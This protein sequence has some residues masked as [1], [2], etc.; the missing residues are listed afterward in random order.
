MYTVCRCGIC[1]YV[2]LYLRTG[3]DIVCICEYTH[4]G[5]KYKPQQT[6]TVEARS[7]VE[8]TL[9]IPKLVSCLSR[10]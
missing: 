10:K 3:L 1:V 2:Y 9:R 5:G 7:R 6:F 4:A 8:P